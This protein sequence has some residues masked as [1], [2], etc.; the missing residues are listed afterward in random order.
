M[1]IIEN[2]KYEYHR[3]LLPVIINST[4]LYLNG[5]IVE[6]VFFL[7]K[8]F[9]NYTLCSVSKISNETLSI[10][11]V[12]V[13]TPLPLNLIKIIILFSKFSHNIYRRPFYKS[14]CNHVRRLVFE[15]LLTLNRCLNLLFHLKNIRWS[16]FIF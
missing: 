16:F 5:K 14:F 6:N 1:N 7:I 9:K 15:L 13:T 4:M 8:E 11:L 12:K 3:K 10:L 2:N